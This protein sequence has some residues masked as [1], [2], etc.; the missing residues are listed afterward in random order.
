MKMKSQLA[1]AGLAAALSACAVGGPAVAGSITYPG[2][3]VGLALG[4][5]LP[6]GLYFVDTGSYSNHRPLA[7]DS[8]AFV[9]IPVIAWSTPWTFFGARI[10]AYAAVPSVNVGASNYIP[11][12]FVNGVFVPG[13]NV[14]VSG[15]Y[16][17]YVNVG[18]AWDLGNHIGLSQFVGTYMPISNSLNQNFWVLNSRT[19]LSYTGDDW[20]L[21]AHVIVGITGN[22]QGWNGGPILIPG[23]FLLPGGLHTSPDYINVDLTATKKF[24]KWEIGLGAFGSSDI[25]GVSTNFNPFYGR[26]SQ[27]AVGPLVGYNFGPLTVQAYVTRDVYSHNYRNAFGQRVYETNL[28][29][30]GVV[31]LW[32]PPAPA[33]VVAKY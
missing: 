13:T 24:D 10:E 31:P 16:N 5:P 27:I 33:P 3:T 8:W 21:T 18:L 32:N 7:Y 19:A 15:I 22:N 29:V 14:A 2:E 1:G 11:P 4:A 23:G 12:T 28:F 17:P 30:R 6:E 25:S 9:N 20:D 26:Q